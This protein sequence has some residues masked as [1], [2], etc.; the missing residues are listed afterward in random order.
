M[1]VLAIENETFCPVSSLGPDETP[2]THWRLCAPASSSTDWLPAPLKEGASF[3]GVTEIWNTAVAVSIPPFAVP[4]SSCAVTVTVATPFA[5][6][7]VV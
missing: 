7:V 6:G 3:T 4:P 2:F 5:S 1:F